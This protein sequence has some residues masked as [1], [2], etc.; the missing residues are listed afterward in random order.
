[1]LRFTALVLSAW[2]AHAVPAENSLRS[3]IE[4]PSRNL[5]AEEI[6]GYSPASTVTDHNAID[7][8]QKFMEIELAKGTTTGNANARAIYED[9]GNSKSFAEIT[10]ASN[11]SSPLTKGTSVEGI[12]LDGGQVRGKLL[13]NAA[14]GQDI[15]KIQYDTSSNQDTWVRC[16][17]GALVDG[18]E[19]DGCLKNTGQISIGGST[20]S[21]SYDPLTDNNNGRTLRGFS[22]AVQ[23]KM[24]ECT[25][26]CPFADAKMFVDY[27]GRPDYADE[28]IAAAFG[29]RKTQFDNGITNFE[30]YGN[31][32]LREV[33]KKGTVCMNVFMYVIREFED[34]IVDCKTQCDTSNCND[35]PVHAWDEGVAFYT[36]SL[37][38][39]DGLSSGRLLHQLADKRCQNFK[40]CGTN[41]GLMG[42]G[43]VGTTS[44]VNHR[45]L[46]EF[47]TGKDQLLTGQCGAARSTLKSITKH[48][49]I[50]LI[51]GSLR[52]AYIVEKSFGGEKEKAEGAVFT[53]AVLPRI[54]A[55]DPSAA[56]I[57]FDNMR[58][59]A[60]STSFAAVKKAYESVYS[61]LGIRCSKIGGL[62][63]SNGEYKEGADRCTDDDGTDDGTTDDDDKKTADDDDK[64]TAD[65]DDKAT[66]DDDDSGG[67][68]NSLVVTLFATVAVIFASM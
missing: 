19:T 46:R 38:G 36:G 24:I 14:S 48:M 26:G 17:V 59:G 2:V 28:W 47:E 66:S 27:Y 41:G 9:G 53:A 56:Q 65:D 39:T 68:M 54:H 40:T 6:A 32:G 55:A 15:V 4:T 44:F 23:E 29:K 10:L 42:G 67:S 62:V 33:V 58:V 49:Y 18:I 57:I 12:G 31:D 35:D 30:S 37:E 20:F 63:N 11:L 13:K 50:P 43:N 51:Q 45:L 3:V 22:T 25:P 8:D 1:M 34:A 60:T 21:Y 61:K 16:R 52:Y 7:L 64:K 5:S